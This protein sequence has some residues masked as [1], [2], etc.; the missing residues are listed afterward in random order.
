[1]VTMR[2]NMMFA[3]LASAGVAL[4]ATGARATD[5]SAA[6]S[7]RL[8]AAYPAQL[9]GIDAGALIWRDGTR[10]PLDDGKG[11][12]PFTEWLNSPDI[13]DMFLQPYPPGQLTAPPAAGSDP[14]RARNAAFFNK[15]YGDCRS[16]SVASKLADVIWLPNK[17]SQRL[18][19]TTVNGVDKKLSAVSAELDQLP[20]SFDTYLAPSQGTYACRTIAGTSRVSAH[21]HGIAIDLAAK[22]ADY[23]RW[24][25][26]G[27]R[28]EGGAGTIAYR[29]EIPME[30]VRIFEK[31]GFIWGGKWHH[32]DTM[33]FEYRPELLPVEDLAAPP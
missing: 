33:H 19:V 7:A 18:K 9:A 1:M 25:K 31:H 3:A 8:L 14:G 15:M 26:E 6:D 28:A 13:E 23:W 5:L 24:A 11:V 10:M 16:D 20:A 4:V 17:K 30:I 27:L 21:G 32:Y 29:N 12:K 2:A 22:H